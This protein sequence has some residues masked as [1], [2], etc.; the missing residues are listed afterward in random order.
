[1]FSVLCALTEAG[2]RFGLAVLNRLPQL[3]FM[4][5]RL[6]LVFLDAQFW[7][8]QACDCGIVRLAIRDSVPLS[9]DLDLWGQNSYILCPLFGGLLFC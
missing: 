1:M 9:S 3:Y 5:I 6:A 8:F 2:L 7:R 4:A